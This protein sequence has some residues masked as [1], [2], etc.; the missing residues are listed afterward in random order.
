MMYK[1]PGVVNAHTHTHIYIYKMHR[2]VNVIQDADKT[3][4]RMMKDN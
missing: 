1:M 3:L 4:R 2:I